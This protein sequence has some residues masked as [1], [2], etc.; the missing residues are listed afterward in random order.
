M[1]PRPG[2]GK[3]CQ[4]CV[5]GLFT[6]EMAEVIGAFPNNHSSECAHAFLEALT[7]QTEVLLVGFVLALEFGS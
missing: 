2:I 5:A 3:G 4:C 7:E 6:F 1:C